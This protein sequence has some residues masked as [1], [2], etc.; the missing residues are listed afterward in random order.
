MKDNRELIEAVKFAVSDLASGGL[1]NPEQHEEFIRAAI[2]QTVILKEARYETMDREVEE[3]YKIGF[4]SRVLQKPSGT[5]ATTETGVDPATG[6]VKL[7][8]VK[9][10]MAVDIGFDVFK[11][12][13]ERDKIKDTIITAMAEKA[14]VDLEELILMGD[15]TSGTEFYTLNDGLFK[16][17]TSHEYDHESADFAPHTVFR[18]LLDLLPK[19]YFRNK[20]E[21]RFYVH[22]DIELLYREWLSERQTVGGDAYLLKDIPA[23]Y[24]GIPVVGV[25]MIIE[26]GSGTT[27]TSSALLVHPK[28]ILYG[29][30]QEI[31]IKAEEKWREQYIPVTGTLW[32][33]VE[34]EEED[35]VVEGTN[36][37]HTLASS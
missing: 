4:S 5:Y 14:G 13:I 33:D 26:T 11:K 19:K 22:E 25:P 1:L 15:S 27:A 21:W 30:F 17:A 32:T 28:N 3:F 37:K 29:V 34:F 31:V 16:L 9:A 12:N 8:A 36:I 6:M 35:A 7:T 23:T 24:L 18:G 10:I 20:N 2:E